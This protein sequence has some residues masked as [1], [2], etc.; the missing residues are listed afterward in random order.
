MGY[1]TLLEMRLSCL[2]GL[3]YQNGAEIRTILRQR[4]YGH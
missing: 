3:V 4:P 1:E 2:N